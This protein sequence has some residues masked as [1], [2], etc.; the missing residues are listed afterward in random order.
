MQ[1]T[2]KSKNLEVTDS[3]KKYAEEKI[4]G[5][6][7]FVEI[8]NKDVEIGKDVAEFF[9]EIEKETM[10]HRKG[11]IFL[12]NGKLIL[13]GKII[14][15]S[16]RRDD[17]LSAIVAMIDAFQVEIKQYKLKN[18]DSVRRKQRIAKKILFATDEEKGDGAK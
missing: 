3:L 6:K 16:A 15:V 2:I 10:H 12:A 1:I 18:K 17:I 9:V 13:P 5:L 8:L 7:R 11:E 14:V 4:G